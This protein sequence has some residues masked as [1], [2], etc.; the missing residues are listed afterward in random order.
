MCII[1]A[2][3]VTN[4]YLYIL[5]IYPF[6]SHLS[7]IYVKQYNKYAE[8]YIKEQYFTIYEVLI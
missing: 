5:R 7:I 6:I 1:Y 4:N 3:K 8:K 2:I